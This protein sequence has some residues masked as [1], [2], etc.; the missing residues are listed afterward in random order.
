MNYFDNVYIRR[1]SSSSPYV[2]KNLIRDF[3]IFLTKVE[4]GEV[5]MKEP[6]HTSWLD[7]DGDDVYV[8]DK[9]YRERS[10]FT[11]SLAARDGGREKMNNLIEYLTRT[12]GYSFLFYVPYLHRGFRQC[13]LSKV[14]DVSTFNGSDGVDIV[15]FSLEICCYRP[16]L[17]VIFGVGTDGEAILY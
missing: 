13:F 8:G 5:S 2:A 9:I 14:M 15:E 11:L 6:F 16:D 7:E 3:D 10:S 1:S 12:D 4:E 17:D